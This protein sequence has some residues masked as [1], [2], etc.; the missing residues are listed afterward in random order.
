MRE[1]ERERE[2]ERK[3]EKVS[4]GGEG[5][6]GGEGSV[7]RERKGNRMDI[8]KKFHIWSKHGFTVQY[9]TFHFPFPFSF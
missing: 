5:R 6:E 3:R 1:R 8:K 4:G 2:R 7:K 9:F